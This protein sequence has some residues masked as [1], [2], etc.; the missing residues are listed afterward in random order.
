[1]QCSDF[2]CFLYV[3]VFLLPFQIPCLWFCCSGEGAAALVG[4]PAV[5]HQAEPFC[6]LPALSLNWKETLE[7]SSP[8]EGVSLHSSPFQPLS[9]ELLF[10]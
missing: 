7:D 2:S 3:S 8:G 6:H 5:S 1:M 9:I 4:Q 10:K